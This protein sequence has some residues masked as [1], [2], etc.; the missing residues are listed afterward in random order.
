M[1]NQDKN[2][3]WFLRSLTIGGLLG[4]ALAIPACAP[5]DR[6]PEQPS[7]E[8]A[9]PPRQV[10]VARLYDKHCRSCH[11]GDGRGQD[12]RD[13]LPT[14]PDFTSAAWQKA[15]TDT[16]IAHAMT[17]GSDPLMPGFRDKLS[18]DQVL[19]LTTHLRSFAKPARQPIA[20]ARHTRP[21]R[22]TP[23]QLFKDNACEKCHDK[24]GSGSPPH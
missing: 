15:H 6:A 16:D 10:D 22:P 3:G 20:M 9:G 19:A 4:T 13:G 5:M 21:A 14:M 11:G 17:E 24:D 18:K 1:P 7:T 8:P 23:E 12:M 2:Q